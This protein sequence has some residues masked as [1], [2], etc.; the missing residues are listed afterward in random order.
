VLNEIKNKKPAVDEQRAFLGK[1]V[2]IVLSVHLGEEERHHQLIFFTDRFMSQ[3]Y[4]R[5]SKNQI[6]IL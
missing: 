2:S 4:N 3:K 5:D 6:F 1:K